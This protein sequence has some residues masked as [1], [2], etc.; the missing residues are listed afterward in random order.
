MGTCLILEIRRPISDH[1]DDD[2]DLR[3]VFAADVVSQGPNSIE[4][5]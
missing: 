4:N 2:A 1:N 3:V 5:L